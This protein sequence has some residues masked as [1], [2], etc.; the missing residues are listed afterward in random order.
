[1]NV[2]FF[3][4]RGSVPIANPGSVKTGGNTTC[5]RVDSQCLPE[6]M[7]WVLDAGSGFVPLCTEALI[8]K[9]RSVN[10]SFTHWHHDHTQGLPL[11]PLTFIKPIPLTIWGPVD[12]GLGPREV[13]TALMR[14]PFFPVDFK[15]VASHFAYKKLEHP[16]TEV[17][18]IHP[19]GGIKQMPVDQFEKFDGKLL[20]IKD[21]KYPK[22][23]CLVIRMIYSNHPESTI[24]YRFEE[25]PTGKVFVF[26]TDHENQDG[27]PND[28][29]ALLK[30]ADLLVMDSQYTR[31]KY[32]EMTAGFGHGTPDYCVRVALE[33]GAKS[34]GLTHHDPASTDE[35]VESILTDAKTSFETAVLA[36]KEKN[37]EAQVALNEIFACRDY[38]TVNV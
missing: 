3:G 24:A 12:G 25:G 13:L 38:Q 6:G 5:L 23:E 36:L 32:N 26:L 30:G 21:G 19:E 11:G 37:P 35:I 8:A 34:L 9:V 18:L 7:W 10:I 29:R 14:P 27:L 4:T 15:R 16:D 33:V 20:P 17:I 2:K 28:L 22:N 31:K 1:M